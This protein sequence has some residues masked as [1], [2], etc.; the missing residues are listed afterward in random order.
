MDRTSIQWNSIRRRNNYTIQEH[1]FPYRKT[2]IHVYIM[3]F[4]SFVEISLGLSP[5]STFSLR[6]PW[7]MKTE[8]I[9]TGWKKPNPNNQ[10]LDNPKMEGRSFAME[11]IWIWRRSSHSTSLHGRLETRHY[12]LQQV[13]WQNL[14]LFSNAFCKTSRVSQTHQKHEK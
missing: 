10:L 1:I 11:R 14:G 7:N 3:W 13:S 9:F 4:L 8:I 12:S 2:H 5:F 6:L